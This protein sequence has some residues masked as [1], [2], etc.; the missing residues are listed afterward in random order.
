MTV[1]TQIKKIIAQLDYKWFLAVKE[2]FLLHPY[3]KPE[4]G[5]ICEL[6][7]V[8]G[9]EFDFNLHEEI[10]VLVDKKFDSTLEEYAWKGEDHPFEDALEYDDDFFLVRKAVSFKKDI[11]RV[12]DPLI[13]QLQDIRDKHNLILMVVNSI[14][15]QAEENCLASSEREYCEVLNHSIRQFRI[16]LYRSYKN[17]KLAHDAVVRYED[18]LFFDI[19]QVDLAFL[20]AALIRSGI[21]YGELDKNATY[22][23]FISKYFY[24][25]N[26]QAGNTFELAN[27]LDKKIRDVLSG[28]PKYKKAKERITQRLLATFKEL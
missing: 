12:I 9:K 14:L 3:Y 24:F 23:H 21:I 4:V 19:K 6:V 22:H 11:L 5:K 18:R 10:D 2:E 17:I 25:K 20:I 16:H 27:D 15:G 1:E 28:D 26:Q 13:A 7:K 8:R